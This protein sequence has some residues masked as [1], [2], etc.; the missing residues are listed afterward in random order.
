MPRPGSVEAG[1][2]RP[3]KTEP[4]TLPPI[5]QALLIQLQGGHPMVRARLTLVLVDLKRRVLTSNSP[6]AAT[7][8]RT[9]AHVGPFSR[10]A[11]LAA[12]ELGHGHVN[13]LRKCQQLHS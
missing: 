1:L 13:V 9:T 6:L 5:E 11:D 7:N 2:N 10:H 12:A 8:A 4:A 3:I